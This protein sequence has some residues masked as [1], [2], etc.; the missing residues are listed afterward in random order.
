MRAPAIALVALGLFGCERLAPESV[1]MGVARGTVRNAAA[2][3][4]ILAEDKTCGFQSPQV[5][6]S[7]VVSGVKGQVGTVT[8]A[9]DSC[10]LD[11]GE[12]HAF[13]TDCRGVETRVAGKV[14][15]RATKTVEGILT[16]NP[17]NPVVPVRPDAA[18]VTHEA[19]LGGFTV[20]RSNSDSSLELRAGA[21]TWTSLP[22]LAQSASKGLCTV[23]TSE[24]GLEAVTYSGAKVFVSSGDRHF[25]VEVPASSFEAQL[26]K[27]GDRENHLAGA[28]RVWD[29]EVSLPTARDQGGL[30][31]TYEAEAFT[32]AYACK[33]DLAL[34][35]NR[36]CPA[37]TDRLAQGTASLTVAAFGTIAS[38]VDEDT[39]CGF[40]SP[41][42]LQG[43][44]ASGP[45]GTIGTVTVRIGAPCSL[46]W[47]KPTAVKTYCDGLER[48]LEGTVRATGSKTVKGW[49]TG[50]P[51][52]PVIPTS[53]DAASVNLTLDFSNLTYSDSTGEKG[54]TAVTG[55]LQGELG[56]R[57]G[58][59]TSTGAC[60]I[61]SPAV[62]FRGLS[63]TGAQLEVHSGADV[64]PVAVGSS[65]LDAQ[66]GAR[67]DHTNWLE[68]AL[69]LDGKSYRIPVSGPA[70]LD[71]AYD[72]AA[73]DASWA[74]TP[75]LKVP[76]SDEEC[77]FRQT[78]GQNAAR[79][80]VQSAGALG[81]MINKDSGCGFEDTW[82]KLNPVDVTGDP[83]N[84]GS[85][86]WEV[87]SCR[88]ASGAAATLDTY[89][90]GAKRVAAGDA[91]VTARR[92]V[93]GQRETRLLVVP[94]IIPDTP[95]AV[96][97]DLTQVQL[98][99]FA[100][101]SLAPQATAPAAKLVVHS[102]ALSAKVLPILGERKSAP[103]TFDVP[104]PVASF[105]SISLDAARTTLTAGAKTFQLELD[106]VA[107]TAQAGGYKGKVNTVAGS[108]KVNGVAVSVP[109]IPLDPSFQQAAFDASYA[110]T[111]DLKA[112]VSP[113]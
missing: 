33:A 65:R 9:V 36:E 49:I 106:A 93:R 46:S 20:Q 79:L 70:V 25:E 67:E 71:P 60:S 22:R 2:I 102:G 89:C 8:W 113:N 47:G 39:R 5:L 104:T 50:D 108:L 3:T 11:L 87:K 42:A 27:W 59:D 56:S 85:M 62:Y 45:V 37:F 24:L 111:D 1:G 83:P 31:P 109:S 43:A 81:S 78:L 82:N 14:T 15:V 72:Q 68:G 57:L 99:N 101:Y 76:Q 73:F 100:A 29:S 35:V 10:L 110:C 28:I 55:S 30:D 18:R 84:Q 75:N 61:K 23:S 6:S 13:A 26:G 74:C 96:T 98:S 4:A 34:P 91:T 90:S 88:L 77:S 38:V 58:L 16:G 105:A 7:A 112:T 19:Q 80:V 21:L 69:A 32:D 94:S 51:A 41:A 54:L 52:A 44:Q 66:S 103:G 40:S 53:R 64:Y 86:T 17:N 95:E 48:R 97:L 107:L 63:W 92:V 12:L